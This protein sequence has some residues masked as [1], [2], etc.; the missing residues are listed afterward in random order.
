[1]KLKSLLLSTLLVATPWLA[2]AQEG[3]KSD[4]RDVTNNLD[5]DGQ[6]FMANN[7]EGD[8]SKLAALGS[9]YV[10]TA[11]ENGSGCFPE[12]MDFNAMLKDMGMD[13]LVA[14][15]RSA[16]FEGDHWV[17]KMYIQNNGSKKGV[18]SLMGKANTAYEVINYA[19]SG[20][21]LVMEWNVDTRQLMSSMK[22][23]PKCEKMSKV[24]DR[25][26][27]SGGTM[28]EML[29]KFTG[30]MSLA[31]RLDDEKREVCP[32]YPEYTFPKLH[33]CMRMEGA[34][35]IWSQV[36]KM[37][38]FMMKLEKQEDGTLLMTP[39]RQRKNMNVVMIMDE[40]NDLLWV[41]TSPEFLAECRGDGDK[42]AA[43]ADFKT[44]SGGVKKGSALAYI[45]RQACLEIRQVKEAKMKKK[46]KKCLSDAMMKRVMDHLTE[47]KNGYF[48]EIHKSKK[49]INYVLKAPCPVKEVLCGKGCG[50]KKRGSGCKKSCDKGC[51]KSGCKG[52]DKG[53]SS[54]KKDKRACPLSGCRESSGTKGKSLEGCDCAKEKS[55]CQCKG[56]CECGKEKSADKV[57]LVAPKNDAKGEKKEAPKK[58]HAKKKNNKASKSKSDG[59]EKPENKVKIVPKKEVKRSP[60][61]EPKPAPKKVSADDFT[62]G[63][64]EG[65]MK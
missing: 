25:R 53:C 14:Y 8:L 23:V 48:A 62:V 21:D 24:L 32:V 59:P 50:R 55:E 36:G 37:A 5:M 20:S 51:D 60:K 18:F 47:S 52:C 11:I 13:Q 26:L 35:Q 29:N 57:P 38:V 42:I 6:F 34:N 19:P 61:A 17:S 49:G 28:E 16:K 1:M 54:C 45:S 43:D 30:K 22:S 27:P 9:D 58:N 33:G 40:E 64:D 65:V 39:R 2:S 15:G 46:D 56:E 4:L 31:V 63:G 3:K 12:G 10:K 7:I 44:M 41:A